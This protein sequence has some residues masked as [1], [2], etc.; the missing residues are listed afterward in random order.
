VID[1]ASTDETG[2]ICD[3][4]A[5]QDARLTVIHVPP[6]EGGKGKSVALNTA[7]RQ[8]RFPYIAVYD[9]DNRP[10][11]DA[12]RI[13]VGE[14]VAPGNGRYAASVG[15]IVKSNRRSTL[16]NRFCSMEFSAFQ[17]AMQAG[18]AQLFD[19]VLITG[20]NFVVEAA[21]V[22][23]LGGWD[24]DAL[25]EDLELSIRLYQSGRRVTFVPEAVSEEQDPQKVRPW[26]RQRMRWMQ[27]NYYVIR[28]HGASVLRARQPHVAA[29]LF[30]LT[31]VYALFLLSLVGSDVIAIGAATGRL[32]FTVAGPYVALWIAAAL[33]FLVTFQLTQ[34][35]EGEDSWR[36]PFL[37]A[38]MY[39]TYTQLWLYVA[40]RSL[41]KTLFG[42]RQ[43]V[44][45]KTPRVHA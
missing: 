40:G 45:D 8:A 12:L 43:L 35:L 27:G 11:P 4:I 38:L 16:L 44:W 34:G 5:A 37:A 1:D 17:W 13:L 3:E 39:L 24:V 31:F 30:S 2:A 18:R 9:A 42:R 14:L 19:L 32:H 7:M 29:E 20:T 22:R 26:L 41:L 25:T 21:A 10:R 23:E 15:R 28:K 6:S 33:I 36:T